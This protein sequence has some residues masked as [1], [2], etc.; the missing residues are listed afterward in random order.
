MVANLRVGAQSET[1]SLRSHRLDDSW[2]GEMVP[3]AV[4]AGCP[5]ALAALENLIDGFATTDMRAKELLEVQHGIRE[6]L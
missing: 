2:S 3:A 1:V 5:F 6:S 4:L